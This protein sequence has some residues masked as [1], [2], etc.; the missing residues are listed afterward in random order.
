MIP[1]HQDFQVQQP[2]NFS[3]TA[4][5]NTGSYDLFLW[6]TSQ[7]KPAIP[8]VT[9]I[10][11]TS[12]TYLPYLNPNYLYHWQIVSRNQC[13]PGT[14][15]SPVRMFA[16]RAFP[17][18][19]PYGITLPDTALTGDTLTFSYIVKNNGPASTAWKNWKDEVFLSMQP[20][21]SQQNAISLGVVEQVSLL[22]AGDSIIRTVSFPLALFPG[23]SW[24]LF[25]QTDA[26]QQLQETDEDNNTAVSAATVYI[27]IPP[28]P[29]LQVSDVQLMNAPLVPASH[30]EISW[31]VENI[32]D[33]TA[34]GG[35]SQ[36]V[37]LVS[38][39]QTRILGYLQQT[40]SL[41]P[42][43]VMSQ[44][45]T[46]VLP[47]I[48]GMEGDI[49][50]EVLLIPGQMVEKPGGELNNLALS[51]T[52]VWLE[53]RLFIALPQS[54]LDED[55]VSPL[56]CKLIRSGSTASALT[57]SLE[58]SPADQINLP[59]SAIIQ[60]NA[61]ECWFPLT[62]VNDTL[63]EGNL[64]VSIIAQATA[65]PSDTAELL[66]LDDEKPSLFLTC[67]AGTAQEGNTVQLTITRN[68]SLSD[69]VQ[70]QL[71]ANVP[72]QLS[73]PAVIN[74]P[75][76]VNSITTD[77]AVIDDAIPE[78]DKVIIL[79]GIAAGYHDG[80]DTL[81]IP[82]NDAIQLQFSISP[83]TVPEGGGIH[84]AIAKI[85]AAVPVPEE[86]IL[87][88]SAS[89]QGKLILPTQVILPPSALFKE[90]YIGAVDNAI[91]E[92]DQTITITANLFMAACNCY[93]PATA[94][95][96]VTA[97][98]TVLDNDGPALSASVQPFIVPED[99]V[100]AGHLIIMRN[101]PTGDPLTV[102]IQHDQPAEISLPDTAVIPAGEAM[103]QVPFNTLNDNVMDG[104]KTVI[105]KTSAPGYSMG[106][107]YLMVTDRN[108][109]DLLFTQL[110]TDT[111]SVPFQS[112]I[113][114]NASLANQGFSTA[115]YGVTISV[116]LSKN[117]SLEK[118]DP[119]VTMFQTG[120]AIQPGDTLDVSHAFSLSAMPGQYYLI[121]TVNGDTRIREL[122]YLN[123][124]SQPAP[125]SVI[126]DF[127]A[128]VSVAGDVFN[129][130]TPVLI[131]G[132]AFTAD[133]QAVP[134]R[135]VN[136]YV[137][138][139]Q[140]RRD[141]IVKSDSSGNFSFS[142]QPLNGEA[143]EYYVGACFPG[144]GLDVPQDAFTVLGMKHTVETI[145]WDVQLNET[146]DS[147]L[148]I[149]NLSGI[150]LHNVSVVIDTAPPGCS[151]SFGQIGTLGGNET[152]S[153]TYSLEAT[154][155]T[156]NTDYVLVKL[157]L[158]SDEGADYAFNAWFYCR[159]VTAYLLIQPAY[160][161]AAMV[162][163][164]SDIEE[165]EIRNIGLAGS[166]PVRFILPELDWM[167]LAS[168]DSMPSIPPGGRAVVS[169]RLTPTPNTPLNV[170]FTGN[171][172]INAPQANAVSLPFS[173]QAIASETGD[174]SVDVVDEFTFYPGYGQHVNGARVIIRHPYTGAVMAE[175]LT[176]IDGIF[177]AEDI[178]E[179]H[180]IL[181][182]SAF[183]HS[184][185]Q[186]DIFIKKGILNQETVIIQYEAVS[187]MW[188]VVPTLIQDEYEIT[189]ITTF[190]TFVP[191][192]VVTID[193]VDSLPD[194][195]PGEVFPFVITVTNR[196]LITAKDVT[197]ILPQFDNEVL[198]T[199]IQP[200]D[201]LANQMVQIPVVMQ[202][203]SNAK[204]IAKGGECP[205][206]YL[207]YVFPCGNSVLGGAAA[208]S[209][210][211]GDA[212]CASGNIS[213]YGEGSG[214]GWIIGGGANFGG[215]SCDLCGLE[216]LQWLA[217]CA[218]SVLGEVPPFVFPCLIVYGLNCATGVVSNCSDPSSMDCIMAGVGCIP[219]PL[220]G[221]LNCLYFATKLC[222]ASSAK[223]P[224][225]APLSSAVPGWVTAVRENM[226]LVYRA[227]SAYLC[228]QMEMYGDT[229]W[230]LTPEAEAQYFADYLLTL[231]LNN[232]LTVT[233]ELVDH[234]P[235]TITMDQLQILVNR[236]NNSIYKI[237][238]LPYNP[239]F[240]MDF[241]RIDNCMDIIR[242]CE[243]LAQ[244]MGYESL[245]DLYEKTEDTILYYTDLPAV[246]ARNGRNDAKSN[247][248]CAS[249][250]VKFSQSLTMTREAFEGS[251][252]IFNG[253]ED[254]PMEDISLQFE[255]RDEAGVIC[256]DLF[257]ITVLSLDGISGIDGSGVIAALGYGTAVIRFIPEK[258]AAPLI[259]V[260]YSFGGSFTYRDPF[261]GL[262]VTKVL[263]PVRLQVNPSPD[264]YLTY[265]M[266]R[267]IWG[268]D[269]LTEPVEPSIPAEL[270]VM[271]HNRGSG[272]ARHVQ[273][274][275]AQPEIIENE[276]GLLID[277]RIVGS[278]L[279][280]EPT[281]LGLLNVEFGDIAG[282]GIAVGQW[283]F[284][285]TLLGHFTSFESHVNH[286]D[287]EGN[288]DLS[289]VGGV[290]IH[291]LIRSISVYG[292]L[293]DSI[294]DFLV[295]DIQDALDNP[296]ALY[297]SSGLTE[298][299]YLADS[300]RTDAPV[301]RTD[302]TVIMTVYPH[303]SGWNY[304]RINDPGDGKYRIVS[305]TRED[306]QVIPLKNIW[307]TYSTIIDMLEP[308]YENKLH[309]ADH[310][311][312]LDPVNYTL[313]FEKIDQNVP[314]VI[315]IMGVPEEVNDIPVAYVDVLFNKSIDP[316][317]FTFED[318]FLRRQGSP[319]LVD[320]TV[321]VSQ[322]GDSLFRVW[323]NGLTDSAGYYV[324]TVQAAGIS[325]LVGNFGTEGMQVDWITAFDV[326]FIEYFIGP[327]FTL[328][329]PA[330]TMLLRF[331]MPVVPATFTVDDIV[332]EYND[333]DT[334][335]TASLVLTQVDSDAILFRIAGLLP[336]TANEGD[337]RLKINLTDIQGENG[338]YG[339]ME[340]SIRWHVATAFFARI[341]GNVTYLNTLSSPMNLTGLDLFR[342]NVLIESQLSGNAGE[343]D[344]TVQ[345]D[346][347]YSLRA[348]TAKP[349]GGVNATDAYL[350]LKHFTG[351]E[352]LTGLY[353]DVADVDTSGYVNA[354]DALN[355]LR[356]YVELI[357]SFPA[358]DWLFEEAGISVNAPGIY[359]LP[360]GALCT[361]DVNGSYNPPLK[362]QPSVQL[363]VEGM[364]RCMPG[365][366][367]LL[368]FTSGHSISPVALSLVLDIADDGCRV[369]EVIPNAKMQHF[370]Y[371][372]PEHEIR[373]A[374]CQEEP[375][376]FTPGDTLFL[377][378]LQ[379]NGQQSA[380]TVLPPFRLGND[381]EFGGTSG[382]TLADAVIKVPGIKME[383]DPDAVLFGD[384]FPN[385]AGTTVEIRFE[386]D[387]PTLV[388]QQILSCPG[389]VLL[390]LPPVT[391]P[392]GSYTQQ[393]NL[394][395][396]A[397]GVYYYHVILK[398]G[399]NI[400]S[401]TRK[402]IIT[403]P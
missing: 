125:Q 377:V 307:Q 113:N 124:Q 108:L 220:A 94:G 166:G 39:N 367:I 169:L 333:T 185:H 81:I 365:S 373:I 381:G 20:V 135:D 91:L 233:Q 212:P 178:P 316:E 85:Q 61:A 87:Y 321:T 200:F 399:E 347:S 299:V 128:T 305:V 68:G 170:P 63:T 59:A 210:K 386:L 318:L 49:Y 379:L 107:C 136:I 341:T 48:L 315:A 184:N 156:E 155:V 311:S 349:W 343:F 232:P 90:F 236:L 95:G 66:I 187:Y 130:N 273:I 206:V 79:T 230:F 355:T 225:D 46:I 334:L 190:E 283:W 121:A 289:L 319:N 139:D 298:L 45:L 204:S 237:N 161:N 163:G 260:T 375:L 118:E 370:L 288:Q 295:N 323:F 100:D 83:D 314:K 88:L 56:Q 131:S 245:A 35:W 209:L 249:V 9:G 196:G 228:S 58:A 308:V 265:F 186:S 171:I 1:L 216:V 64:S 71:S 25:V 167:S 293:D 223:S 390:E 300:A 195:S 16:F 385:P 304:T 267:N 264:L 345:P 151:L 392:S 78:P 354:I 320:S 358:G 140:V 62:A 22:Q 54:A 152:A 11:Q 31:L 179:G 96:N 154:A 28:L 346:G 393:I 328:G 7:P 224:A 292:P 112:Q 47:Q 33:K 143:G 13:S 10:T 67:S 280:G 119:L 76:G 268:D 259:P 279:S 106:I 253:D 174:L 218:C 30:A 388:R 400:R 398:S 120:T 208:K 15:E 291:E 109:P 52:S 278:N 189:L 117:T 338:E 364:K 234:T 12:F 329:Q 247:S 211:K 227:D 74:L 275:S 238:G 159:S 110:N 137:V 144:E 222:E 5:V 86:M 27:Q 353:L 337:Y 239:D 72:D 363:Q 141:F 217:G 248:V 383:G 395:D 242:D 397:R 331:T 326:P 75:L 162:Q 270:A 32:G 384:L 263:A 380:G 362:T 387:E 18:L 261:T 126:P 197:I 199:P 229:A 40:D 93:I 213:P 102:T 177:L 396:F 366:E 296:D 360:V 286:L 181:T 297:H 145:R 294:D 148:V 382:E 255:I 51:D 284:T 258:D 330:D 274:E 351:T 266:Q 147:A 348:A 127:F 111:D 191:K 4:S 105:I 312:G 103:V 42:S 276:K 172:T 269:A 202:L 342:N 368:P 97:G 173:I 287:S 246:N 3:W 150:P 158:V 183:K 180:Y 214:S 175:G 352:L 271:I 313:I 89:P 142:F 256:N 344:F 146:L 250:T 160:L 325:D 332:L 339:L 188:D 14:A 116:Y 262:M 350:M 123:N 324:F 70:V 36:K 401:I 198:V 80:A 134:D 340:Q 281:Q 327:Q 221:V 50:L 37:S 114:L 60:Q 252:R 277:F 303:I 231:D 8:A 104:D 251:L 376:E 24:Y 219:H 23:G 38:G 272:T 2:V 82:S 241:D 77:V 402:L 99:L 153:L 69:A 285:S 168:P 138:L 394:A 57:V 369:L 244:Q 240:V 41:P 389:Q 122:V 132:S 157:R 243:Y 356:R 6:R 378:R 34:I 29:D 55:A 192:P 43:G 226:M 193:M 98:I 301:T 176:G 129:G 322:T 84:A 215:G 21:F 101:T 336:L 371:N 203:K 44:N 317:T 309:F 282:G 361:G 182:V 257:Q 133:M 149:K 65:Y 17:D 359:Q 235:S 403:G 306:G 19:Q 165:F 374:W 372:I 254:T 26:M 164:M 201:L 335:S 205:V 73:F 115:A 391:A 290:E 357:T 310:F 92:G 207:V 53:K 302:T 194:L